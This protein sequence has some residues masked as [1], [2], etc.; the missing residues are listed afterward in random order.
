MKVRQTASSIGKLMDLDLKALTE[1]LRA[2]SIGN[3]EWLESKRV[4]KYP[5]QSVE[6]A[7][8]LNW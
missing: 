2:E 1:R 7:R 6:V 4:F 5:N 3:P 8:V